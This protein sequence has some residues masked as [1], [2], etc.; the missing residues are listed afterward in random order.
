MRYAVI[1]KGLTVSEAETK[2]RLVG[3]T[4]IKSRPAMKQIFCN[5]DPSQVSKLSKEAGISLKLVKKVTSDMGLIAPPA[6]LA[7]PVDFAYPQSIGL[8]MYDVYKDLRELY[9]P[10]LLG[11]GL[12]VAVL[13]SGIRETHQALVGKVIHS[14]NFSESRTT[15]DVYGHG[16]GVAYVIAGEYETKSGVAPG[17]KIMNM[18]VLNDNG[19]GT[20][21]PVV[22][23]IDAVCNLVAL[24]RDRGLPMTDPMY[25]NT[26]NLS[27]GGEDDG[28]PDNP[29]RVAA[30]AA[31]EDYGIQ[32]IAAAGNA[33]PDFSTIIC[34]ACDPLVIAVGGIK[35]YEFTIWPQSSRGPTEQGHVKPDLVCWAESIELAGHGADDEYEVKSGTSFSAPI[36]VGVDGLLWDLTRRVYGEGI[37]LTYH[38]WLQYAAVYCIKPED[39]PIDKDN[40]Y[41]YGIPA[42]GNMVKQVMRPSGPTTAITDMMPAMILMM[43]MP[44]MMGGIG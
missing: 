28:D 27:I 41:G 8:N 11:L 4:G 3:A 10:G 29:M 17:A 42:V 20:D 36:L 14:V 39:A 26:I 22:D 34:P 44:M 40:T 23:A 13:D 9:I 21:E 24:A 12:T 2:C 5:L 31:Y 6:E 19:V 1:L 16:T 30:R 33:G 35:S 18:K 15:T 32:V 37:R 43:M 7:P 38:D 25:P